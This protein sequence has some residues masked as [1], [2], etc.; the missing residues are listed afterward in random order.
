MAATELCQAFVNEQTATLFWIPPPPPRP[1]PPL[2]PS[3]GAPS[4]SALNFALRKLK[5]V[6]LIMNYAATYAGMNSE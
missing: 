6:S 3:P 1:L 2:P 4:E 5:P